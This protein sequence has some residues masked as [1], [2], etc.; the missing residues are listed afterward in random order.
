[1]SMDPSPEGSTTSR[2]F[3]PSSVFQPPGRGLELGRHVV[4]AAKARCAEGKVGRQSVLWG[5]Q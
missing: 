1:M 2:D 3:S 4:A 5:L